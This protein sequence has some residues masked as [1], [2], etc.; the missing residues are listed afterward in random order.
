MSN[1]NDHLKMPVK[2]QPYEHQKKAFAFVMR[3]FG[4]LGE[5]DN[6]ATDKICNFR[7]HGILERKEGD[8]HD[9]NQ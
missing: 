2:V 9:S 7:P 3:M 6:Q 5:D 4:V 8:A 1:P